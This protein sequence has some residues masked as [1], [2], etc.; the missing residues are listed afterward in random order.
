MDDWKVTA[1]ELR[2]LSAEFLTFV[3]K[4]HK[5]ERLK[6]TKSIAAEMFEDNPC[7]S[8]QIPSIAA[9]AEGLL[10]F[11]NLLYLLLCKN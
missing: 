4:N 1:D 2:I 3:Q 11:R 10:Y 8:A 6:V 5:I 7:K 9:N